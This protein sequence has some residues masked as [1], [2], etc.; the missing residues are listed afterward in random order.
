[1]Q[2]GNEPALPDDGSITG[3]EPGI[4]LEPQ[5][6]HLLNLLRTG[7]QRQQW[8]AVLGL[9][10]LRQAAVPGVL[11]VLRG[12]EGT[13]RVF[14]ATTLGRIGDAR[15]IDGLLDVLTASDPSEQIAAAKALGRIG[16]PSVCRKLALVLNSDVVPV[17]VEVAEA[18]GWLHCDECI[19]A[20]G[21]CLQDPNHDVRVS[22]AQA[23]GRIGHVNGVPYLIEAL[24]TAN[25]SL[26]RTISYALRRIGT[27]ATTALEAA[28]Q[29]ENEAIR[30]A[31]AIALAR[32]RNDR[33]SYRRR[34][35][36]PD[37]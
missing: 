8:D 9:T 2:T 15:A 21:D 33:R 37:E 32:T 31:A 23:L 30:Q 36:H 6:N 26:K 29:H 12:S 14:A 34:A 5:V 1:M 4:R 13:T 24:P 18:L 19:S 3:F 25:T 16:D 17:R 10:R 27:D 35:G 22:T 20:L 7:D 11:A 28:L